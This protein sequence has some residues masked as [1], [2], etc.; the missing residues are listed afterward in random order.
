MK[1]TILMLPSWYP[2]NGSVG[3]SF[4]REQALALLENFNFVVLVYTEKKISV[5]L[6]F[7]RSLMGK[8]KPKIWYNRNDNGLEEFSGTIFVPKYY[9][10]G[11]ALFKLRKVLYKNKVLQQGVGL[12]EP[13]SV[14]KARDKGISLIKKKNLLPHFDCVLGQTAQDMAVLSQVFAQQFN[15]P[16][17]VSEHGPFPW[18]G[19]V[20]SDVTANAIERADAFLA[21]SNDKIRQV[22]LQNITISPWYVGN[23]VDDT[24]YTLKQNGNIEKTFVIVAAHSFYKNYDMFI[25]TMEYLK[26]IAQKKFKILIVGYGA[27]KGYSKNAEIL[28]EKVRNSNFSDIAELIPSVSR[29]DMPS[30][31]NKADAFVMT[32]IQEGMPVSA[33]EAA[34]SGLPIFST[35][36]GGVED[37]VD[38]KIG[39]IVS[40]LDYQGLAHACNDFLNGTVVYDSVH[41]RSTVLAQFGKKAFVQNMSKAIFSI[42]KENP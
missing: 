28:E 1:P 40:L 27:N 35:R 15:V 19:S 22:L 10:L 39:K 42:L 7:L 20:I 25:K 23:M 38:D 13:K 33:L 36:C 14:S 5:P 24:L 6:F 8:N 17:V 26:N 34:M 31:Y 18:P 37:Y 16:Y 29:E 41:I 30:I 21:I 12:I 11:T 4:F 2:I 9:I 3:G 32:S